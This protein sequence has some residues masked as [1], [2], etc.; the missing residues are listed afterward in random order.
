MTT[1]AITTIR[2][3]TARIVAHITRLTVFVTE[4]FSP[5]PTVKAS[6]PGLF[7]LELEQLRDKC[8]NT[9]TANEAHA[10]RIENRIAVLEDEVERLEDEADDADLILHGTRRLLGEM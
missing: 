2:S 1:T 6:R 5:V 8:N 3:T 10:L 7:V 9:I 4:S